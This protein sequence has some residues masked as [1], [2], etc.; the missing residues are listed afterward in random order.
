MCHEEATAANKEKPGQLVSATDPEKVYN[1][2]IVVTIRY[3][4]ARRVVEIIWLDQQV[5]GSRVLKLQNAIFNVISS[6][7]SKQGFVLFCFILAWLGL[8]WFFWP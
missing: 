2:W 1:L 3:N 8:V 7:Y 4:T 5:Y 6:H